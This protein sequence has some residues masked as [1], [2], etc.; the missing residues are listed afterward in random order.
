MRLVFKNRAAIEGSR[1]GM[2]MSDGGAEIRKRL[3]LFFH[4]SGETIK[5]AEAFQFLCVIEVHS[6]ERSAEDSNGFVIRFER[7]RKWMTILAAMRE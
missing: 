1:D 2:L 6:M 3:S 7:H 4:G 5:T